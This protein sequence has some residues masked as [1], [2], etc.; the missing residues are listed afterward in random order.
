MGI[1]GLL[2]IRIIWIQHIVLAHSLPSG[3]GTEAGSLP[4]SRTYRGDARAAHPMTTKTP[5]YGA[6]LVVL[7]RD[8]VGLLRKELAVRDL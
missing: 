4:K 5:H 1:Q 2:I 3:S 7:L 6:K 8:L